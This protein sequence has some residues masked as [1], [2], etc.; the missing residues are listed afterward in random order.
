M[1][2]RKQRPPTS[3]DQSESPRNFN[4]TTDIPK[5]S[6]GKYY[7]SGIKMKNINSPTGYYNFK[8]E[9]AKGNKVGSVA[10]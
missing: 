6:S 1:L 8:I 10:G 5:G 9:I 2:K 3:K 7:Y 4:F